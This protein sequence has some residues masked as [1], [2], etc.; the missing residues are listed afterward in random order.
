MN[1]SP[2]L[3]RIEGPP[4]KRD[5]ARSNRAGDANPPKTLRFRGI[6]ICYSDLHHVS[7]VSGAENTPV[8]GLPAS[9]AIL[10]V[11]P[12]QIL[13][14]RVHASPDSDDHPYVHGSG[15]EY[16]G[17]DPSFSERSSL[18]RD[19]YGPQFPASTLPFSVQHSQTENRTVPP[20][21]VWFH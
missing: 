6:H 11:S 8:K 21:Q 17:P 3:S 5:A 9:D 20:R 12:V 14:F 16:P 13:C 10:A 18:P 2:Y 7:S 4:P 19:T 1:M 15:H